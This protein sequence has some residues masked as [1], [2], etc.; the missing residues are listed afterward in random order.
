MRTLRLLFLLGLTGSSLVAAPAPPGFNSHLR[1]RVYE[2]GTD[3]RPDRLI[4][5]TPLP[6]QQ[7]LRVPATPTWYVEPLDPLT[8]QSLKRLQKEIHRRSI[9]GLD[10][11]GHEE[12]RDTTL[13]AFTAQPHLQILLL[14]RTSLT[15]KGL[16][17]L[18]TFRKLRVLSLGEGVTA[19]GIKSLGALQT[20]EDLDISD[21]RLNAAALARLKSMPRL[22]RITLPEQTWTAAALKPI[23][24][25]RKLQYVVLGGDITP[26]VLRALKPLPMLRGLDLQRTRLNG[27]AI[28]GLRGFQKL[29]MVYMPARFTEKDL[30]AL[31]SLPKLHTLDLTGA[32]LT[33]GM[34]RRLAKLPQLKALALTDAVLSST[35]LAALK[36]LQALTLLELSGTSLTSGGLKALSA[37]KNL[38]VLSLPEIELAEEDR[39]AL[40]SLKQLRVVALGGQPLLLA[41]LRPAPALPPVTELPP[42]PVTPREAPMAIAKK[43]AEGPVW[44]NK[45]RPGIFG[46]GRA[47]ET[48]SAPNVEM[49]GVPMPQ[50]ASTVVAQT[51]RNAGSLKNVELAGL[52]GIQRLRALSEADTNINDIIPADRAEIRQFEETTENSLGE[53]TIQAR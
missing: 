47:S 26:D 19:A 41:S 4:G 44:K 9:P 15:D 6:K 49:G 2:R 28:E 22:K 25:S 14:A 13:Q 17:H 30:R 10:L 53:F 8:P 23:A 31:T 38:K 48:R 16:M 45:K 51:P 12:V 1:L 39:K 5:T 50:A 37:F 46:E 36:P 3:D 7:A 20:L 18:K 11:S 33:P 35:D 52:T 34:V 43:S 29:E 27:D 21:T 42:T 24:T 32:E 40:L